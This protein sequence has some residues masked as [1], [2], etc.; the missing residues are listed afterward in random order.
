MAEDK[1]EFKILLEKA[2]T[3]HGGL[4]AGIVLG[5]RLTMIGMRELGMNPMERNKHLIVYVEI[6][7]CLA[8]AIQAIT[9]CSLGH[10]TLKYKPYGKFAATYIDDRTGEGVRVQVLEKK[11]TEKTGADA[12]KE[13]SRILLEAPEEDLFRFTKV[14]VDIP[15][16]DM[17]GLPIN[18][19]RCT[20]CREMIVDDKEVIIDG[21]VLCAN[22]AQGSYYSGID[23]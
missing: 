11:R 1:S 7:R 10:R 4:C 17:P 16:G 8:D 3:F 14:H 12:M 23:S 21:E 18:R 6:D 2:Q 15:K 9:G 5:T 19:T 22:C 20:R 13:A